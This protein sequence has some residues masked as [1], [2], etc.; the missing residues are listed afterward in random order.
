MEEEDTSFPLSEI[1]SWD[2][3]S[4]KRSQQYTSTRILILCLSGGLLIGYSL[5][6]ITGLVISI[7]PNLDSSSKSQHHENDIETDTKNELNLISL[8]LIVGN[9]PLGNL[10]GC[11]FIFY[12]FQQFGYIRIHYLQN[13]C[14]TIGAILICIAYNLQMIFIGR[15]IIGLG[16]SFSTYF[17]QTYLQSITPMTLRSE[18]IL[19][20]QFSIYFGILI[21]S[22]FCLFFHGYVTGWRFLLAFQ[23]LL[24]GIHAILSIY[25]PESPQW[26]VNSNQEYKAREILSKI[27]DTQVEIDEA[28]CSLSQNSIESS[29]QSKPTNELLFEYRFGIICMTFL[30]M[31][32]HFTGSYL[33]RSYSTYLFLQIGFTSFDSFLFT[34][35]IGICQMITLIWFVSQ[36]F[37]LFLL[38]LTLLH[39]R[40]IVLAANIFSSVDFSSLLVGISSS[41]SS[42]CFS[43]H[44][45]PLIHLFIP[46]IR[47][48][49]ITLPHSSLFLS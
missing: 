5:G 10:L 2:W 29:D 25:L 8:G 23:V 28:I 39:F 22:L 49:I 14:L 1:S 47:I 40:E 4:L 11:C 32:K 45:L 6:I 30:L 17:N 18:I 34:L 48:P 13:S 7:P 46:S 15:F 16:F 37:L 24:G 26:L 35:I 9:L 43:L 12:L 3:K 19:F 21:S 42:P 36:V 20:Y 31:I 27:Y 44:Q 38:P 41:S 33:L